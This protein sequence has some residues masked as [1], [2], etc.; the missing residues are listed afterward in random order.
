[1]ATFRAY[2]AAL[3]PDDP[4]LKFRAA[5]YGCPGGP[6]TLASVL[7]RNGGVYLTAIPLSSSMPEHMRGIA[8]L[9]GDTDL[10]A[11]SQF[12]EVP[13]SLEHLR[14]IA[15]DTQITV[16]AEFTPDTDEE[17]AWLTDWQRAD[18]RPAIATLLPDGTVVPGDGN[19]WSGHPQTADDAVNG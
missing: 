19:P 1:M 6:L 7:Q 11:I 9:T 16:R 10:L 3:E 13:V 15:P 14:G 5:G 12:Q 17:R 2:A 4:V 8:E 18:P